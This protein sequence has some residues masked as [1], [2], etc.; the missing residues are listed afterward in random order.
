[1]VINK[2]SHPDIDIYCPKC[3]QGALMIH[4]DIYTERLIPIQVMLRN[5]YNKDRPVIKYGE[6]EQDEELQMNFTFICPTPG[7]TLERFFED[8]EEIDEYI[9]CLYKSDDDDEESK[10]TLSKDHKKL[11]AL[12]RRHQITD[13]DT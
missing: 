3:H 5:L 13:D 11:V 7:C 1:M 8:E 10:K 9:R 4:M 2:K 12:V 6:P